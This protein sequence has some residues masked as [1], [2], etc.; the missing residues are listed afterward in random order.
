MLTS[1]EV[2][3]QVRLVMEILDE[4]LLK[5]FPQFLMDTSLVLK[6]D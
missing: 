4:T 2:S 6:D 3:Q 5:T 1:D